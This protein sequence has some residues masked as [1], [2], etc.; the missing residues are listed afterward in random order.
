[1]LGM[2]V[3]ICY[4]S[5]LTG[6]E[7]VKDHE[8]RESLDYIVRPCSKTDKKSVS[9]LYQHP[10]SSSNNT[11]ELELLTLEANDSPTDSEVGSENNAA[12]IV[13]YV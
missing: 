3:Y 13:K 11:E 7:I 4:H 9:M 1:M 12:L 2:A 5:N 6:E 8:F 10:L